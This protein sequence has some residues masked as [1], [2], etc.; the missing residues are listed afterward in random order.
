MWQHCGTAAALRPA[1]AIAGNLVNNNT[2]PAGATN[3]KIHI[4]G[5]DNVVEDNR[6][7]QMG[8][9][10]LWINGVNN[11][12]IDNEAGACSPMPRAPRLVLASVVR[13]ALTRASSQTTSSSNTER[14]VRSLLRRRRSLRRQRDWRRRTRHSFGPPL[15]HA[16]LQSSRQRSGA[17]LANADALQE[18]K[19]STTPPRLAR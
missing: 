16:A 6:L 8:G 18:T 3:N 1:P 11:T 13:A 10:G 9:N 12:F 2:L 15:R 14:A 5:T 4:Q 7:R 17:D 19:S